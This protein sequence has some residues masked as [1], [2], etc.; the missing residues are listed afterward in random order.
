MPGILGCKPFP[1]KHVAQ[2]PFTIG[3]DDLNPV[4][5]RIWYPL[6]GSRYFVIKTGPATMR[7][8]LIG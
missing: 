3:A 1:F 5:I 7:V 4:P 6:Y 2:M 8:K